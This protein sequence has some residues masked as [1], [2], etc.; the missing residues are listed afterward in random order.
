[1][2]KDNQKKAQGTNYIKNLIFI[3][4]VLIMIDLKI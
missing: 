1:M 2:N 4:K 3:Y